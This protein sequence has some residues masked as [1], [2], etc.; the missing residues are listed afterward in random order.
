MSVDITRAFISYLEPKRAEDAIFLVV[1][2]TMFKQQLKILQNLHC[3][4]GGVRG[5]LRIPTPSWLSTALASLL[6]FVHSES[7]LLRR[8]TETMLLLT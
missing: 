5:P 6:V 3:C 7:V 1:I 2:S 4:C 8:R